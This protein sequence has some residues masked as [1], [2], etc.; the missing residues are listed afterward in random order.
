[1]V[2]MRKSARSNAMNAAL[3]MAVAGALAGCGTIFQTDCDGRGGTGCGRTVLYDYQGMLGQERVKFTR[4]DSGP[5]ELRVT[6]TNGVEVVYKCLNASAPNPMPDVVT[7][8]GVGCKPEVYI[9]DRHG[10]KV[11]E[12]ARPQLNDYISRIAEQERKMGIEHIRR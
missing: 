8:I 1:M 6:R 9:N 12:E 10:S 11:L 4:N 3:A 2:P 5:D 7:I